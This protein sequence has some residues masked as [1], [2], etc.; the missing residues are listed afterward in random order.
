MKQHS[1]NLPIGAE[2]NTSAPYNKKDMHHRRFVSCSF[3]FYTDVVAEEHLDDA[4]I[5]TVI[6]KFIKDKLNSSAMEDLN[7][8]EL[9]IQEDNEQYNS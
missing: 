5:N 6:T 7:I 2:N 1:D 4:E 8:D 3:S 9:I